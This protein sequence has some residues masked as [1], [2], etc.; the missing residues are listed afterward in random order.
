M[1]EYP[2]LDK[3]TSGS[4]R[5]NTDSSKLEI[6]NGEAWFEINSTSP[7]E[8]TGGAR[9]FILGGRF[10]NASS[11]DRIE[12]HQISTTGDG[13]DFGNLANTATALKANVS[14][15]SRLCTFGDYNS[16]DT[17]MV[18]SIEFITM[19]SDGDA[20]DFGDMSQGAFSI[21]PVNDRT[22]GVYIGGTNVYN[23]VSGTFNNI[24]YITIQ[25]T[26]NSIDFG[27]MSE[28]TAAGQG[29]SS[30]TRGIT[31]GGWQ[32]SPANSRLNNMQYITIST[33]GNTADFGDLVAAAAFTC[34]NTASNA[35]RGLLTINNTSEGTYTNVIQF[36]TTATLGNSQDFGDLARTSEWCCGMASPTR[37]VFHNPGGNSAD[38]HMDYV[39]IMTKGNAIDFGD[40]TQDLA[41]TSAGSNGHGGIG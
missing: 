33:L 36:V 12:R 40:I 11:T 3:P 35:I 5:F 14:D 41:R 6:Y 38:D 22:R 17:T 28:K 26:G 10:A 34:G 30:P 32:P 4:I 16:P 18:N 24:E 13:V 27:D 7:E 39:E 23:S 37:A 1:N 9:G 25:T 19:A 2:S 31:A 15:R 29:F 20:T 8:Q 21:Q